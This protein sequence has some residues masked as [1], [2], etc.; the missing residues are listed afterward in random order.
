MTKVS[1]TNLLEE[2]Y[3]VIR[4]LT[5][6]RHIALSL[7]TKDCEKL[8]INA[9][10]I[11]IKQVILNILSN[12]VKYNREFG[13]IKI[14]CG[15]FEDEKVKINISDT[16]FGISEENQEKIFQPF[17]RLGAE[18]G[19]QE[20]TGIGLVIAQKIIKLLGGKISV[21]SIPGKGS[22]F[23]IEMNTTP[24]PEIKLSESK[25]NKEESLFFNDIV[26]NSGSKI[27]LAEDNLTNQ[28]VLKQQLE[29][30][31]FTNLTFADNGEI[32]LHKWKKNDFDLL[33]TDISMPLMDG[34]ELCKMIRQEEQGRRTPIIAFS[35]N[36][37]SEDEK[38]SFASGMDDFI[39]KPAKLEDL[40]RVL[41]KWLPHEKSK[42]IPPK[43]I[44]ESKRDDVLETSK[45]NEMIGDN[46]ES[47]CS[48]LKSFLDS[49]PDIIEDLKKAY[50]S[51]LLENITNQ[52]HKLKSS[53]RSVGANRLADVC[54]ALQ[55]A[56]ES[57]QWQ[58]IDQQVPRLDGLFEEIRRASHDYC[59]QE[60]A[61]YN[62]KSPL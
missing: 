60:W 50:N 45:L 49:T 11:R 4:P 38:R 29:L 41:A 10:F 48:L 40:K 20:G 18:Y 5:D 53:T 21:K 15:T 30:L 14:H 55:H 46:K 16:G 61:D 26:F 39:I 56:G 17:S 36:V 1:I 22:T 47:H 25:E 13:E 27:L 52:A 43:T 2:C 3:S 24:A 42:E 57:G 12:A 62:K 19:E 7:E 54:E 31:G 28:H 59:Y 44:E 23:S 51:R 35:A 32:A 34:Y 33:M 37:F 6:Q 58:I 8:Y 9:D